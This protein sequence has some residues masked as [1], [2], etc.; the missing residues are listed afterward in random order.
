MAA[1]GVAGMLF[2]P[3]ARAFIGDYLYPLYGVA[4]AAVGPDDVTEFARTYG[5]SGGFSGASALYRGLLAAGSE[6]RALVERSPLRMPVT[7]IGSA[8]GA[9]TFEAFRHVTRREVTS[10]QLDGVGHYVAQEAPERLATELLHDV[11]TLALNA[12]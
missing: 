9:F 2:E 7:A 1:P 3:Q 8:G 6:V 5:R 10:V 11:L 4:A 12:P